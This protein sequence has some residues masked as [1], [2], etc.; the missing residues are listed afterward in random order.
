MATRFISLRSLDRRLAAGLFLPEI[1]A[2]I[3]RHFTAEGGDCGKYQLLAHPA[4]GMRQGK[5]CTGADLPVGGTDAP[6]APIAQAI[7]SA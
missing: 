5:I 4:G 3:S 6:P 2:G 1:L 7:D